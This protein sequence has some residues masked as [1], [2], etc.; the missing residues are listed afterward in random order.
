MCGNSAL[1]KAGK[2]S[3]GHPRGGGDDVINAVAGA[4]LLARRQQSEAGK[5]VSL[6]KRQAVSQRTLNPASRR[7][8][9]REKRTDEARSRY[10]GEGWVRGRF[11]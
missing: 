1:S 3:I 7:R 10:A 8:R 6:P 2:D 4:C 9:T 11:V 5:V